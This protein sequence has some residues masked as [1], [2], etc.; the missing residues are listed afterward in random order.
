MNKKVLLIIMIFAVISLAAQFAVSQSNQDFDGHFMMNVPFGKHYRNVEWCHDNGALGCKAE[1]WDDDNGCVIG[2]KDIVVYY[3]NS[4]LLSQGESNVLEHALNVLT[5]TYLFQEYQLDGDLIVLT[6]GLGM[7]RVPTFMV[8][9]G[10]ESGD[11]AVFV[12]GRDLDYVKQ[13]AST[14]EF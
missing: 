3:Y 2:E 1:Y 11:E 13:Y 14:I 7:R 10:S 12:G 6:N 4:S 9:K 5:T 8:G